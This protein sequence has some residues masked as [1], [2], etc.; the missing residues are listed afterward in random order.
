[1]WVMQ[2]H[3]RI[4]HLKEVKIAGISSLLLRFEVVRE[5]V[6]ALM[7]NNFLAAANTVVKHFVQISKA[8]FVDGNLLRH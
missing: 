7:P 4:K 5:A 3:I 8:K 1:M 2:Q 6:D